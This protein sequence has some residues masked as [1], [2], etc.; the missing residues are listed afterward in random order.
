[1]W[2]TDKNESI[3]FC[4]YNIYHNSNVHRT[5]S[6]KS[7]F[8]LFCVNWQRLLKVFHVHLVVDFIERSFMYQKEVIIFL[9]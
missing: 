7:L 3:T 9:C 5:S 8:L 2:T 4:S 6:E 1:M